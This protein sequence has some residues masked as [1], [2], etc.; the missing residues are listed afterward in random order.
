M[1]EDDGDDVN[2]LG[3]VGGS[4][5]VRH[6]TIP[7]CP[8]PPWATT[9]G[10]PQEEPPSQAGAIIKQTVSD[11]LGHFEDVCLRFGRPYGHP[12]LKGSHRSRSHITGLEKNQMIWS[13]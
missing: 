7:N 2:D 12:R 13:L 4:V 11:H 5:L 9:H 8:I 10:P 6:R 1:D 3:L